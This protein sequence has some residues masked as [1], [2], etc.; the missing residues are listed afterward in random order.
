MNQPEAKLQ[1]L[2]VLN[3]EDNPNDSELIQAE[4]ESVWNKVDLLRVETREAFV[5]ALAEFKPDVV[6]SDFKL[7]GMNGREALNLVRQS[8]PDI[9][10][11]MVTGALA[12]I[13]AVDLVKLGAKDYVMKDHLPRLTGAVQGALSQEQ[14]IRARKNMEHALQQ[15]EADLKA[16]V[17]HS[18]FAMIVDTGVGTDEKVV[19]MNRKF[20]ELF[21]YTLED[22]PDVHHW[23][24]LAYPDKEYR[25]TIQTEFT[26]L[27][28]KAIQSHGDIK[29]KETTVTCKDG[30]VR[31][32]RVSLASIGGRNIVTFEDLT[33][34]K[35]AEAK[36]QRLSQLYAVLSHCNQ[37]IVRSENEAEL[38]AQTCKAAVK[39]G[40][41]KM[42]WIGVLDHD[43]RMIKSVS[44]FGTN[45]EEYLHDI[46]ISADAASEYG[47]GPT[48]RAVRENQPFWCQDFLN[49][50][51][52]TPWHE[53]G[54]ALGWRSS[55]ALPLCRDGVIFGAF[56]LYASEPNAFDEAARELLIEMSADINYALDNFSHEALRERAENET[57]LLTQRITLATD[58]AAIGIW[59]WNL[60]TDQWYASPT[61]FTML[62]YDAE[63][64]LL[65]RRVW[66][67]RTHPEDRDA[68]A[69]K[70][71]DVLA[72]KNT[73]YQYEARIRHADGS[74]RCV[75]VVG[76]VAERDENG[77]A[78]RML[79]VRIDITERKQTETALQ[80]E[81]LRRRILM[82]GS[83]DAIAIINQ[84]YQVVEANSRFAE[85]LGYT[86][87]EVLGL[88][89][90]DFEA[91]MT[92]AEIRANFADILSIHTTIETRHRRKDGTV[93]D[94]EVSIGGAMVGDEP[95]V[96]TISRD[97]SERKHAEESLRKL[98]LAVEQSPN[99]VVITDLEANL[100][101]VN[102]AFVKTTGYSRE[103]AIGRNPRI[104]HSG[105][106][107][108]ETYDDMWA[109]L[110]RG[111]TWKGEFINR[112]KDG[113]E[114]IESIFVSPVRD[115][116]GKVTHY[117]GI[118][119]DITERKRVEKSLLE[120]EEKFR[121]MSASAQD[122]IIMIDNDGNIS[123]WNAA[124]EKIFGHTELEAL[125]KNLHLL[126][127][128]ARFREAAGKGFAHFRQSGEGAL[129]GK[130]LELMALHKN[131]NEF[132]IELSLSAV[133]ISGRW[134]AIGIIRNITER[135]QVEVQ[136]VAQYEHVERINA[137][138][139][140]A[141]QQLKQAQGQLMQSEKMAAIG[142]LAAGVAH[143]INNPIGYV[144][145]NLGT[146]EKYLADIFV[147]LDKYEAAETLLDTNNPTI[148]DLLQFKKKA[149]LKYIREDT[150]SLLAESHQGLERVKKIIL[151]LKEFSHADSDDQWMWADIHHGL[152]S[153]L[154][155]VW[156]ELKYK[157]EVIKEYGTLPKIYQLPSEL[158]Q[159]FMNLLVNAAQA[160]E[161]RGTITLRTGQEGDRIWVEVSD[162]GKGIPAKDFPRLFDPFFTTK[163]VGKGTGLGLSVSYKIVE[164]H[165]GKIEVH[166]EVGKGSTFRVWL[167][168]Q[169]PETKETK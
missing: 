61:Y 159:V 74:Y 64:G 69:E 141:N 29:P 147:A 15:S 164:K 161:V 163:P 86:P 40:G 88:H 45:A 84:Q 116:D 142:L 108:R 73:P 5:R 105:K 52:T 25:E 169:Q 53:R 80:N 149:D 11:I 62:G 87:E 33:E 6:L 31:H 133:N 43:T 18:P 17:E 49:S 78:I 101:Y 103:E 145:S 85:I 106:N 21:G 137:Q 79:G 94:V 14:S 160:I 27:I 138:L 122:A 35:E 89:V 19:I 154:N 90:W 46:K 96:F 20:T 36:T 39:F 110:T 75:N 3:L 82:E 132:Q 24:P 50:P 12:D 150:K 117:L 114:Y 109:H 47:Q 119:E 130:T 128:P 99:L 55:A 56:T 123:F 144:N 131:G 4:L 120:S 151:D 118:K 13:E 115:A 168:V 134:Q 146:L 127:T 155:V 76:R 70:I 158:N 167:P 125:G 102:E 77:K 34:R 165:H 28:E 37:A 30:S 44:S 166:S 136:L 143:E 111:E 152:D 92:E 66:L 32:V 107:S 71:Q 22:I 7:P 97:I 2:R 51:L 112:R 59:D 113:S 16:L 156:N 58:A 139:L 68:I 1:Q 93:Y 98:S 38:F 23:W 41:F 121:V 135:K 157:C 65:D 42:A 81:A 162:T 67:E 126:L 153:T 60:I 10:V 72:G 129:I 140:E 95:L 100:E 63:A 91:G 57:R 54:A 26:A 8:H 104:L 124:A 9:P 48:G 83:L 148:E